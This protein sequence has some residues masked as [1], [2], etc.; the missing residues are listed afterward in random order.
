MRLPRAA[1]LPMMGIF[2]MIV[3]ILVARPWETWVVLALGYV[4]LIPVSMMRFARIRKSQ[5]AGKQH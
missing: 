4:S 2:A 1:V 3:A 5:N